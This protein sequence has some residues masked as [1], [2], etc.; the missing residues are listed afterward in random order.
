MAEE[1]QGMRH[2][3]VLATGTSFVKRNPNLGTNDYFSSNTHLEDI[4]ELN[5][6]LAKDGTK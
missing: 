5:S 2:N 1:M 4:K 3:N 6:L